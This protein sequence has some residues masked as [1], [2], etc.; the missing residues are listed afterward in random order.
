MIIF[1]KNFAKIFSKNF[2][3][4]PSK[5]FYQKFQKLYKTKKVTTECNK[6]TWLVY[7][8]TNNNF[9]LW[10]CVLCCLKFHDYPNT[11]I[12]KKIL[13]GR[14]W[15]FY[16]PIWFSMKIIIKKNQMGWSHLVFYHP[17]PLERLIVWNWLCLTKKFSYWKKTKETVF[18]FCFFLIFGEKEE[19]FF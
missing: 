18:F 15:F 5:I 3:M 13:V 17:G 7:L 9:S 19:V 11:R 12:S 2:Q 16:G 1:I 6:A 8:T 10:L 4:F 14:N